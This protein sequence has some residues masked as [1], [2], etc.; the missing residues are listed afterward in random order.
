MSDESVTQWIDGIKNG[1]QEAAEQ[2]WH[3]YFEK[4]VQYAS[5]KLSGSS[6]RVAD[7]EDVALSAFDSFCRNAAAGRFP[8]L[9]DR[10][11]LW[12]ILFA[13]TERKALDQLKFQR[14]LK[15]GGGKVRG[16]SAFARAG[17]STAARYGDVVA[18]V[19]PTPEFAA[20]V[21]EQLRLLIQFLDDDTLRNVALLK[22]EGF[23]NDEI[24]AK[25]GSAPR[26][27]TRK[28]KVIRT[29]WSERLA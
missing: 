7:E 13:I 6:R 22:M 4:L 2:I 8:I 14:R 15:R 18:G 11:D 9:H 20:E 27:V 16:E 25:I 29:I 19:E 5:K 3:L 17:D 28:L 26:S 12:R 21:A 23:T 10:D 1:D 24:A